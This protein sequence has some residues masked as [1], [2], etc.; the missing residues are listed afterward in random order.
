M[1]EQPDEE[2]RSLAGYH[3]L[4]WNDKPGVAAG[5]NLGKEDFDRFTKL[6]LIDRQVRTDWN[7]SAVMS[8]HCLFSTQLGRA[9]ERDARLPLWNAAVDRKR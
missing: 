7:R 3:L 6:N 4:V 2:I 1:L 8:F 9:I 5:R